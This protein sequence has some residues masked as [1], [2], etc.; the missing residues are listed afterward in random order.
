[1]DQPIGAMPSENA[2]EFKQVGFLSLTG[3]EL[4]HHNPTQFPA[5]EIVRFSPAINHDELISKA[6]KELFAHKLA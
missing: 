4:I 6:S 1:M 5:K 3:I 2:H